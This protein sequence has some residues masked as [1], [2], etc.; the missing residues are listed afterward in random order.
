M[1]DRQT[2]RQD[3]DLISLHLSFRKES[4]LKMKN[5]KNRRKSLENKKEEVNITPFTPNELHLLTL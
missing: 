4:G 5:K 2:R 1:G 3:G